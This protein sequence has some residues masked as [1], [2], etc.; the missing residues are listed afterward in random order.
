MPLG[1]AATVEPI[2]AS[3]PVGLRFSWASRRL[4]SSS[5]VPL[6]VATMP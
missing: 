4:S 6:R 1:E 5:S 3:R 2:I